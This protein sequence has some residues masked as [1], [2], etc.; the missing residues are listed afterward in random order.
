MPNTVADSLQ[1]VGIPTALAY[2]IQKQSDA[3]KGSI[4]GLIAAGMPLSVAVNLAPMFDSGTIDADLLA[5]SGLNHE[6]ASMIAGIAT[7]E[8]PPEPVPDP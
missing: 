1:S 3:S 2:E 6:Q 8:P 7:P 5:V 4:S